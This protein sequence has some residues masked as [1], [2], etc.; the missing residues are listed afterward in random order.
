[1]GNKSRIAWTDA[2]ANVVVGC[3]RVSEGCRHCYAEALAATRLKNTRRY[4]GL[5]VV[6]ESGKPQ[7][8][9]GARLDRDAIAQGLRWKKP[10]RIFLTA[11]GDPFHESLSDNQIAVLFGVMA[12]CRQHTF[13]VLTKRA[14][15]MREWFAACSVD[16]ICEITTDYLLANSIETGCGSA[17]DPDEW[18]LPNVW[19]GVSVEDQVAADERIPELLATPAAVRFLSCEPLLDPVDLAEWLA[20]MSMCSKCG[21][22]HEGHIPGNCPNCNTD[23]LVTVWGEAQAERWRT[24]ERYDPNNS[25]GVADVRGGSRI[26]WVIVGGE[27]GHNARPFDLAWARAIV[28]QCQRA[29]IPAFVKQLG[30]RAQGEW[31]RGDEP[32]PRTCPLFDARDADP[33]KHR[34][35]LTDLH[36]GDPSEW[37]ED[38]RVQQF[39]KMGDAK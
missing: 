14:R 30:L 34:Y 21:E 6:T 16:R 29:E 35:M 5:A 11:M 20:A 27:S 38:L 37:P 8:T 9:G 7:W 32:M 12:A 15:R 33:T 19:L 17:F 4:K 18:P 1:M 25:E 39:P 23:N 22:E 13:Q 31:F 24:G 26:D 2:T 3:S 10:R 28:E 36:G